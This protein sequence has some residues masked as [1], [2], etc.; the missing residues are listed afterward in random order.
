MRVITPGTLTED[1][2]LDAQQNNF[3]VALLASESKSQKSPAQSES[4]TKKLEFALAAMDIS[5]GIFQIESCMQQNLEEVLARLHPSELVVPDQLIQ[6]P[7]LYELFQNWRKQL[8]PLP[9]SRFDYVNAHQRLE[10]NYGVRSLEGFGRFSKDEITAAGT[11][12]DYVQLTQKGGTPVLRPPQ[13]ISSQDFLEIDMSTRRNLELTVTPAGER[14]GSLLSILDQTVTPQGSRLM[15][16]Y[17]AM[18]LGQRGQIEERLERV[19]FFYTSAS[20]REKIRSLLKQCPDIERALARLSLKRGSPRDLAAIRQGLEIAQALTQILKD[21]DTIALNPLKQQLCFQDFL[22]D[23]LKRALKEEL[24]AYPREGNFIAEGYLPELDETR[25]LRDQGT[26][27]VKEL[28]QSYADQYGIPTLK[29]KH[30]NIIG[31]HIEVTLSHTS[32]VG[33]DFIHRQTTIGALRYST[34]ALQELEQKLNQAA[35]HAMA[36]ELKLFEDLVLEILSQADPILQTAQALATFDVAVSLA[37]LAIERHYCR[38]QLDDSQDFDIQAG[39]H[40]VVEQALRQADAAKFCANSCVMESHNRHWLLTGPN[41][42]GKSTFLRQNA[43]FV[44]MVQLGS[45]VPAKSARLGI[46]DRLFSRVGA[47][48]D[49]ARGRSTFMV[50]MVETAAILNQATAKSFVI[51][52]RSG[53][54]HL[55]I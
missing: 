3:L 8:H 11:L 48:D 4:Q 35:S 20:L 2:L 52:R 45:Y 50:E 29:I 38:P 47:S 24:P 13:K 31:Y 6:N 34:L 39:R 28:Q 49:L 14:K 43:L 19:D 32:K 41:M 17:I 37:H 54:R 55:N 53:S 16:Q 27:H 25:R 40:P 22:I 12:L 42:A 23:R 9:A 7:D 51:L 30:N 5:A 36:L 18:P 46:V 10:K 26:S 44:V 15:G 33:P 21:I 1:T